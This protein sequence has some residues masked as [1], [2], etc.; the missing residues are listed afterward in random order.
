MKKNK[1]SGGGLYLGR[2]EFSG[3]GGFQERM[4]SQLLEDEVQLR[5]VHT[6]NGMIF[7]EVSPLDYFKLS[8]TA[9]KNG[10]RIRA[11]KRRGIYFTLNRYR[12]RVGLYVGAL[13]FGTILCIRQS[14]VSAITVEGDVPRTEI[15]QILEK[16]G[17][18]QGCSRQGLESALYRAEHEIMLSVENCAWVDVSL[19]G[20]RVKVHVERG[21]PPPEVEDNSQPRN[22]VAARSAT[23]ISQIVRKGSSVMNVGSGVR[24]GDML[25]SGTVADNGERILFLR[26][27]A[28]IIGEFTESREFFVPYSETIRLADGEQTEF[29]SLVFLDDEYP[30]Y[31]GRAQVEDAVCTEETQLV[32]FLGEEMPFRLHRLTF[33]AYRDVEVTR[34]GEDC[35]AELRRLKSDFEENFYPKYEIVNVTEKF[36]PQQDGVRLVLEYTLRGDIAQPQNIEIAN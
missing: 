13:L 27:D 21:T 34:S 4:L 19:D 8:E 2:V 24:K 31:F 22:I 18:T 29:C 26:A 14:Q 11:G 23:I 12:S 6:S 30:L 16:S 33:T 7:G 28:E 32:H 17:I 20:F 36:M 25:V 10:V 1:K 9:R 35:V 5:G 15:I 3:F